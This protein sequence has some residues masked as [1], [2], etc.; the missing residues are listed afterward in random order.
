[1]VTSI[2]VGVGNVIFN[3]ARDLGWVN[4][5]NIAINASESSISADLDWV[6]LFLVTKVHSIDGQKSSTINR[7]EHWAEG[8]DVGVYIKH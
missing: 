7:P 8:G 4:G 2:F 5:L 6:V 3:S 1:M